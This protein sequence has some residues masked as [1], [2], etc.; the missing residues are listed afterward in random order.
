M[1]K[2]TPSTTEKS[3]KILY[4]SIALATILFWSSA[5]VSIR[6]CVG[7]YHPGSLALLRYLAASGCMAIIYFFIP[8]RGHFSLKQIG[9]AAFCGLL[10]IGLYNITLNYGE[11]VVSAALSSFVIAQ[12]PVVTT[13]LAVI[14]L[15]ERFTYTT[16]WG[17]LISISGVTLIALNAKY[18]PLVYS[19]H[20]VT[21]AGGFLLMIISIISMSTY[22]VLQKP[23]LNKVNPLQFL[24]YAIWGGTAMLLPFFP[25]LSADLTHTPTLATINAIYLGIFPGCLAYFL[26]TY[27]LSKISVT[28]TCSLLYAVPLVTMGMGWLFLNEMPKPMAILGGF[29]ALGGAYLVSRK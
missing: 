1:R 7:Y 22:S 13:I 19:K 29:I 11:T 8:N 17:I 23:L 16:L 6:Y 3:K 4:F 18:Q 12:G 25:E 10:G 24:C 21:L 2:A 26:W 5:F 27:L 9:I 20:H 14:F 28:Q 15:G